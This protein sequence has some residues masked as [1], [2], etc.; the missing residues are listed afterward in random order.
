MYKHFI[1]FTTLARRGRNDSGSTS[2]FSTGRRK[3]RVVAQENIVEVMMVMK[4]MVMVMWLIY[5][6]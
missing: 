3:I 1:A 2:G 6:L 5:R 4:M